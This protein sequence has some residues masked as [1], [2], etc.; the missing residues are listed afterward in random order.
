MADLIRKMQ[1]GH[2]VEDLDTV[3]DEVYEARGEYDSLD[4]RLDDMSSGTPAPASSTP[5]MDGTGSA[6][7][8]N[9]YARADHVHPSDTSKQNALSSTQLAA[10]NSGIDSTKVAQ[11]ETNKNNIL[12]NARNGVANMTNISDITLSSD[13]YLAN[14]VDFNA[15]AC[16]YRLKS[17]ISGG[18][19]K[20]TVVAR[21]GNTEVYR[22][23]TAI[24]APNIE[25]TF[26]LSTAADSI[27][28]WVQL[29][30]ETPV[31]IS[32]TIVYPA[33][34]GDIPYQPYA[35]SNA[36]L[37]KGLYPTAY[38]KPTSATG[39]FLQ[40]G[41]YCKIGNICVVCLRFSDSSAVAA[42]TAIFSG[43]P[44]P[45]KDST[46]TADRI[47]LAVANN[48]NIEINVTSSGEI[49]LGGTALSGA[50]DI[51][52]AFAVYLAQS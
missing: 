6:G 36:E 40:S 28:I 14:R 45:V 4:E 46:I 47:L 10:V 3:I 25:H 35:M 16:T 33:A 32:N 29:Q 26:T 39:I 11:I 37:T 31:A 15:S 30:S 43:L 42:N 9:Q 38:T 23:D 34:L 12:W 17:I 8:S 52:T 51:I 48:K 50:N 41:G 13:G 49:K 27:S 24:G 2:T 5:S 18:T 7:T 20:Y 21:M 1:E 19:A 22:D 44:L